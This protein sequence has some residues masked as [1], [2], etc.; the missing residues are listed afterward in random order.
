MLNETV[1][2]RVVFPSAVIANERSECGNLRLLRCALGNKKTAF[3]G[4]DENS[5]IVFLY[6]YVY[7]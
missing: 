3:S 4:H 6:R 1:A 7:V 5:N 2:K